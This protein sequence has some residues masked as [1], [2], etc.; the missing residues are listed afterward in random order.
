MVAKK[1]KCDCG[2]EN[3]DNFCM[4]CGKKV[5]DNINLA[6]NMS[7]NDKIKT[8]KQYL[9][10][11]QNHKKKILLLLGVVLL[12]LLG[13][14]GYGAYDRN[15]YI[16]QY[17]EIYME[18]SDI[19]NDLSGVGELNADTST[20][21]ISKFTEKLKED[22][23]RIDEISDRLRDLRSRKYYSETAQQLLDIMNKEKELIL[24]VRNIVIDPYSNGI[25][26]GLPVIEDNSKQI[27]D[28][29]KDVAINDIKFADVFVFDNLYN[30]VR[31]YAIS[32]N[33]ARK[34]AYIEKKK[35]ELAAKYVY[36]GDHDGYE[37]YI[38]PATV[39]PRPIKSYIQDLIQAEVLQVKDGYVNTRFLVEFFH[40]TDANDIM[41]VSNTAKLLGKR[42]LISNSALA[43][44]LYKTIIDKN[45]SEKISYSDKKEQEAFVERTARRV[46]EARDRNK[47]IL[48]I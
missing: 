37:Y 44:Q 10:C 36:A 32:V 46:N 20:D 12:A 30:N 23:N 40:A 3:E 27:S 9:F 48:D 7:V 24:S 18:L 38:D 29:G 21:D 35:Q 25:K 45:L 11:G 33:T 26:I 28:L 42:G 43:R 5:P 1:W 41:Y 19:N 6:S 39:P 17:R 4:N 47:N 14:I 13:Y 8:A 22:V 31:S 34:N 16:V 2:T 15:T